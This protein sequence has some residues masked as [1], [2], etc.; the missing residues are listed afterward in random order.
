MIEK[1]DILHKSTKITAWVVSYST[2]DMVS[3]FHQIEKLRE[4]LI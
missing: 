1:L 3:N 4:F 2:N